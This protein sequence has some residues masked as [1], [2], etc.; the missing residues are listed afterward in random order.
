[1]AC[2]YKA[3][4]RACTTLTTSAIHLPPLVKGIAREVEEQKHKWS[5]LAIVIFGA[6]TLLFQQTLSAFSGTINHSN[7]GFN[8]TIT[9][10]CT[11]SDVLAAREA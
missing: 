4:T 11:R 6:T 8:N 2:H 1:M 5:A 7:N 9:S 10:F 3:E